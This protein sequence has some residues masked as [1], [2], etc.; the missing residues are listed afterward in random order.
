[1]AK[2]FAFI[3][4]YI[5]DFFFYDNCPSLKVTIDDFSLELSAEVMYYNKL[6]RSETGIK[7]AQNL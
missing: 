3:I 7:I 1:M 6:S 5:K 2:V 4:I